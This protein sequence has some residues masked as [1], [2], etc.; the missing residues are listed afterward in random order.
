MF[1]A[2]E[3]Q[4]NEINIIRFRG[5]LLTV[6][7]IQLLNAERNAIYRIVQDLCTVGNRAPFPYSRQIFHHPCKHELTGTLIANRQ[8]KTNEAVTGSGFSLV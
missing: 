5:Y 3:N 8:L 4:R 6:F 7:C 2:S 1:V